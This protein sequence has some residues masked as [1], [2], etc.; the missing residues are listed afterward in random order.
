MDEGNFFPSRAHCGPEVIVLA[1]GH[2]FS[3]FK[4]DEDVGLLRGIK[5]HSTS[6]FGGKVEL[7]GPMS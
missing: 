7:K 6:F 1:I 5:I 2:I 4:P 3:G